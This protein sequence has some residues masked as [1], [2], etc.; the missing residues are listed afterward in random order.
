MMEPGW[1]S[2]FFF[3]PVCTWTER[4]ELESILTK[5]SLLKL[6]VL[7]SALTSDHCSYYCPTFKV[8]DPFNA[9]TEST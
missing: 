7:P 2:S 3:F 5:L 4:L 1:G 8:L 6:L 9:H